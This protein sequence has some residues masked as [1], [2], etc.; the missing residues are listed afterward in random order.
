MR[1]RFF[2][3]LCGVGRAAPEWPALWPGDVVLVDDVLAP[4]ELAHDPSTSLTS[5]I[6]DPTADR[7]WRQASERFNVASALVGAREARRSLFGGA[8]QPQPL[9]GL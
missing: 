6:D 9:T 2:L 1:T 8:S 4:P 5:R 3:G 7:G